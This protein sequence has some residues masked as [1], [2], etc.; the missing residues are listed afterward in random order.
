MSLD[1]DL[2]FTPYR[3]FLVRIGGISGEFGRA[4]VRSQSSQNTLGETQNEPDIKP[5]RTKL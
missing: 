2:M 4:M 3:T 1:F 5:K